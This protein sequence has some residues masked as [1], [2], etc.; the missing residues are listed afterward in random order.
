MKQNKKWLMLVMFLVAAV[1]VLGACSGDK[2]E[3]ENNN[4]KDNS[5]ENNDTDTEATA[6][7][8]LN[9]A[10]N[11]QPPMLDPTGTTATATRDM[12]RNIYEQLVTFDSEM[13]V[14]PMLAESFEV[15]EEDATVT[16]ELR[17]GVKFH[18]GEEMTAEDVVA[19]MERWAAQ[20]AQAISFLSGVTFKAD[21]DYTVIAQL[22]KIGGID[23]FI[24]ADLTQIAAIMPKEVAEAAGDEPLTEYIGTGPYKFEE[25]KQ[26]Q[27][28]KLLK[29]EDYVASEEPANGLAGK[30]EAYADEI[31]FHIVTDASTRVAGL[32]SGEYHFA[33]FLS[34]DSVPQLQADDNVV[35]LPEINS[36]PG[37]VFNKK[38]G[39]FTDI[40][41]RQAFAAG[42]NLEEVMHAA[43]GDAEFYELDPSLMLEG[44]AWYTDAGSENYD[45]RDIEKAK[46]L[47]DE[48]GYNGEEV[49]I[50]TSREYEDYYTFSVVV[51]EQLKEAGMN[52]VLDVVDWSTVLEKRE[53][54]SAYDIFISG[55]GVRPTPVQYPFLDSGAE[56]PGWTD[57]PEIDA[58]IE[59]IQ[60]T[61]DENEQK[62]LVEELQT[63]F[64]NYL[65]ILKP[66]NKADVMGHRA[67][68]E[69]F[70]TL[71][72]P[73]LWN[74][75]IN[76]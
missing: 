12:V 18:N 4:D 30:K 51:Q 15:N 6:G 24:F 17:Q 40:K 25:W 26:D 29:F 54:P 39:I 1:L 14:V 57:S 72:G 13:N 53:D 27:Y 36:I 56:W 34:P 28:I 16:F 44:H 63:E 9:F 19:S 22:D 58:L 61:T 45:Q 65:P 70:E 8:T 69:G 42:V 48:A 20:S 41:M 32:Q 52:I 11:A 49:R 2:D 7:G 23:M 47:L 5:E 31:V 38:E 35:T 75:S 74:V 68:I 37:F 55:W 3:S 50:L 64:W 46:Q 67:S 71:L 21:G 43:Y 76:E 59:D 10:F 33:N 66:G 62:A 73:V 60:A